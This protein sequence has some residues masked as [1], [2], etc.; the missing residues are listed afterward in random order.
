MATFNKTK[1]GRLTRLGRTFRH[2][3]IYFF[4]LNRFCFRKI[5]SKVLNFQFFSLR[6]KPLMATLSKTRP[7]ISRRYAAE[8]GMEIPN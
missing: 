3:Y 8:Q 4:A 7:L 6:R 2:T 1:I 5:V